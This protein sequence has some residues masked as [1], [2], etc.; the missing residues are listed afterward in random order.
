MPLNQPDQ[1]I[2][3]TVIA[4]TRHGQARTHHQR[5]E[6]FPHRHVKAEGRLLQHRVRRGQGIGRLHPGQAV[7]QGAMAVGRALGAAGRPGRVDHIRQAVAMQRHARIVVRLG[8]QVQRVEA[9]C[10]QS[11]RGGLDNG[12][13]RQHMA[14]RQQQAHAAV[15][16][17]V[18]QAVLGIL[19]VQRHIGAPCFHD[20]QQAN[21][22]LDRPLYRDTDQN[23]GLQALP[24]QEVGQLVGPPVE[25][26]VAQGGLL[27]NQGRRIRCPSGLALNQ[28]MHLRAIGMVRAVHA[29][30]A[31]HGLFRRTQPGDIAQGQ[32]R[33]TG[34]RLEHGLVVAHQTS[35]GLGLEQLT[36]VAEHDV[37]AALRIF[38]GV[39]GQ[40][41]LRGLLAQIPGLH[42]QAG[43]LG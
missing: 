26:A 29:P 19:W 17:H 13:A 21:H 1:S 10:A 24:D 20:R 32:I 11:T 27:E 6:E 4:G 8:A 34:Q 18:G 42:G 2:R 22:H 25:L 15:L 30:L 39:Q 40:L 41:E 35:D 7:V 28:V 23:L 5:P 33:L 3:I 36:G 16:H 37:H 38:G 31:E 9:P 12:Q 43:H 14:L